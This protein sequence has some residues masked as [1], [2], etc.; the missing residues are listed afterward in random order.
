MAARETGSL[1]AGLE[2]VRRKF[3]RWRAS[4]KGRVPIPDALWASA[5]LAA[6]KWGISRTAGV[7]RVNSSRLK[8]HLVTRATAIAGRTK[9][10]TDKA[11]FVEL[12]PF[13][14]N[15]SCECLLE[16][17]DGSGAKMRVRIRSTAAPDLAAI[18][19]SFWNRQP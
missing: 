5:A 16:L 9:T 14:P 1:P 8:Q 18:G 15:G 4:R 12:P 2:G 17:E 3:E 10:T 19:R 13:T 11:H 7:L 6:D